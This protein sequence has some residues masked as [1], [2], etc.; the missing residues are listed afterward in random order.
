MTA[1][2]HSLNSIP[3]LTFLTAETNE[4]IVYSEPTICQYK[5][6]SKTNGK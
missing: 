5:I 3:H 4:S 1:L 6:M 2:K